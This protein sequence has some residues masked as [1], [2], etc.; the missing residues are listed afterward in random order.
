MGR[1]LAVRHLS[2]MTDSSNVRN[3]SNADAKLVSGIVLLE[4]IR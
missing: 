2:K 1:K 3:G 4:S